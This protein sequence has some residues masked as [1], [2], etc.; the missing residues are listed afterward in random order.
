MAEDEVSK[1]SPLMKMILLGVAALVLLGGLTAGGMFIYKRIAAKRAQAKADAAKTAGNAE[2][3]ANNPE[4]E[5][6]DEPDEAAGKGEGAAGPSLLVLKPIVNLEGPRK[7]IFL[8]SEI[9][10]VFRDP[11]LG[12]LAAS[13]KPTAENSII[14]AIVL[15]MLSGKTVEEARDLE[16]RESL[17]IEIKDRLNAKFAPKPLK[18]G[19]KEDPKKKKPKRPIK[20]VLIVDWAFQ[21]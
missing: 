12:R 17:R 13:D 1:K 15:E 7:N 8:K 10:I 19:E 4:G 3:N 14:R 20:D 18:P 9:H 16:F 6:E 11:E 2:T 21:E 5:E